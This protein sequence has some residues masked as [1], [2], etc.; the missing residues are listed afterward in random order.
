MS[1]KQKKNN[2]QN[3]QVVF[4]CPHCGN[5]APYFIKRDTPFRCAYCKQTYLREERIKEVL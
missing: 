4:L 5:E 2:K 3:K 1:R